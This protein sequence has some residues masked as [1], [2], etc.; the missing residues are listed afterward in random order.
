M[1]ATVG[2][3]AAGALVAGAGAGVTGGAAAGPQDTLKH[4]MRI[5]G[6]RPQMNKLRPMDI[7]PRAPMITSRL[8]RLKGATSGSRLKSAWRNHSRLYE[9]KS[10]Y[11][12]TKCA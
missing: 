12:S 6:Q 11:L 2:F 10:S 5:A 7:E 8:A 3:A 9:A 4:A 1:A